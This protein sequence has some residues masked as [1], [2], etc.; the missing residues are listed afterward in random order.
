[1]KIFKYS[2]IAI[3]IGLFYGCDSNDNDV[4][5]PPSFNYISFTTDAINVIESDTGAIIVSFVY[6]GPLLSQDL[7]VNYTI[8]FPDQNAAQEGVDYVLPSGSGSFVLPAGETTAEVTLIESLINDNLSVGSRSVIFNLQSA[9]GLMLGKPDNREAAS[10][11]V[12][13]GEDDLFE[14]GYSSFE[15]VQTFGTFTRYPRPA[16]TVDPLPNVQDSDSASEAPLVSHVSSGNELGFTA[17]FLA[18]S[19]SAIEQETMGVYNGTVISA[20]P[21]SF[22]AELPGL[23][24]GNQAYITSDLDG[25]LTLRF[26]EIVGLT[27]DVTN[28][29]LDV[30]VFFGTTSWETEDGMVVYF[31]TAD[32]LGDPILS[33]FDDDVEAA[34]GT[35]QEL[36]IPLPDDRLATG[37]LVVTFRNGAGTEMIILDS[38]SIKGIQ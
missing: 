24:D 36:R 38:I 29:V 7:T 12:T 28:A 20:N 18:A 31:E 15:D 23:I 34:E 1:M 17:S 16:G 25:F 4:I 9:N 19:V 22:P 32:G 30:K 6:S 3:I 33:I 26:D 37:R 11:T 5:L 27:P 14:F 21:D 35:W 10:V 8:S 13:V 2:I